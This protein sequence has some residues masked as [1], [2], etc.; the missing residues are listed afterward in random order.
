MNILLW[1]YFT[2]GMAGFVGTVMRYGITSLFNQLN[3][4]F[5]VGTFFIN[6]TGSL[7]LGWFL[8]YA[9]A[10]G[11]SGTSRLAIAVGFVGGYTTFSTFM[12]DTAKL[13]SEGAM[14]Q[15]VINL[16]GSV[17]LGLIGVRVGMLLAR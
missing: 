13:A 11:V 15:S 3:F 12:Y 9:D 1:R 7:I 5:P 6:I 14:L 8:T 10:H 17:A 16:V 2:I 4:R